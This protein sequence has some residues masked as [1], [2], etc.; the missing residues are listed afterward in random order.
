MF[1]DTWEN[2]FRE[3]AIR[4]ERGRGEKQPL[5]NPSPQHTIIRYRC[6]SLI[7]VGRVGV[8]PTGR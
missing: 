1:R 4:E 5:R 7:L 6:K 8:E 3:N 2:Y